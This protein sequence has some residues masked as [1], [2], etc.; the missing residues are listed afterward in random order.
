MKK[1]G[2]ILDPFSNAADQMPVL[3]DDSRSSASRDSQDS[4][5]ES[6]EQNDYPDEEDCFDS[7]QDGD[8]GRERGF[9]SDSDSPQARRRRRRGI[10]DSDSDIDEDEAA[11]R[12]NA[13]QKMSWMD[14]FRRK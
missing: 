6:A 9:G 2:V 13:K 11:R 14:R 8:Y 7:D 10:A 5:R 12:Y 1:D 4:N 3:D